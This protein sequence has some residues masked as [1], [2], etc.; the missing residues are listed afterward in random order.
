MDGFTPDGASSMFFA[1][2]HLANPKDDAPDTQHWKSLSLSHFL[3]VASSFPVL[4]L[5]Q[6]ASSLAQQVGCPWISTLVTVQSGKK[7]R[8]VNM[9]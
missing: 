3:N 2:E 8:K 6:E 4:S 1:A 9:K 5:E 7:W